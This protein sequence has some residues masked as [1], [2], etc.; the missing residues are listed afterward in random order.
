MRLL[1]LLGL[2]LSFYSA[3]LQAGTAEGGYR[4]EVEMKN[5]DGD[6]ILLGYYFGKAQYLKDTAALNK[7]KFVF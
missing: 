6:T 1:F 4:I 2:L 5:F 3:S 7:G